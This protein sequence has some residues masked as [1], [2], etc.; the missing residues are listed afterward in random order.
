MA[1]SA[2]DR[3]FADFDHHAPHH[4][5]GAEAI[6]ARLRAYPGLPR[7]E[8]YGGFYLV[9]RHADL[10]KAAAQHGLFSSAQG[11]ALPSEH[12]TR[13]IPEEVDPPQQRDYRR[14]L[15]PFVSP[16]AIL[17]A[18][19]VARQL[20]IE[21]LERLRGEARVDVVR[22]FTEVYPVYL[23]LSV[24]GFP[25]ADAD[26]LVELVDSLIHERGAEAGR[27]AGARLTEY[28]TD[29]LECKA[30]T[31]RPHADVVSA[32]ARGEIGGR[33]LDLDEKISMTRLLLFGG[34]TT[35]NLALSSTL[36]Q[37][38]LRPQLMD[39]LRGDPGLYPTA[40]EEFVRIAS[41]GTYLR[42]VVNA[43][44]ELG[45]TKLRE[46]EQVL[47]CFGAANRDSAIFDRPDEVILGRNPNPHLGFGFGTHRCMGSVLAK[48]EI[49]V[50]V[51][52]LL[53]RYQRFELDP[54]RAP[55]WG[56]GETQ[57][58]ESLPLILSPRARA[59]RGRQMSMEHQ[60]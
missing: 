38:T 20:A 57:G 6:W 8:R 58:F 49:R 28:L 53:A 54:E 21:L 60:R 47:L 19:P 25:R 50:V 16:G 3:E 36:Y 5:F 27:Q 10:R 34:F 14:L 32:I 4:R 31:N 24:F 23:S 9:A 40:V 42:R 56:S 59:R 48:L 37:F 18:G 43:D 11:V 7:S 29:L 17:P 26:R 12:R 13:H 39:A 45:G 1:I 33:P 22:Q 30:A 41:P 55:V 51:E 15:D 52:E 35:V 44:A 2:E 46:G